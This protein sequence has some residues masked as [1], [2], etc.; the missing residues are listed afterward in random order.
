MTKRE[1][2]QLQAIADLEES[3]E[4]ILIDIHGEAYNRDQHGNPNVAPTLAKFS[5]LLVFL[6]REAKKEAERNI[7]MQKTI[8]DLTWVLVALTLAM[9][10]PPILSI[11]KEYAKAA[12]KAEPA[13]P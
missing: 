9:V 12:P 7:K 3:S 13:N 6:S 10:V 5:T 8:R 1:E 11:V 2:Q 4:K